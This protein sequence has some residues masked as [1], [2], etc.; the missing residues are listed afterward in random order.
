M[1]YTAVV[2]GQTIE[3]EFERHGDSEIHA[4]IGDRTYTVNAHSVEPGVYWLNLNNRSIEVAVTPAVEGYSASVNGHRIALEILDARAALRKAAHH[5]HD[6]VVEVRAPMPGKIVKI[7][8]AE[9][10]EVK[11]NQGL[12]VME[13]MKMQN[14]IKSPKAGKVTK[15]A[16]AEATT[17][18]AGE[19]LVEVE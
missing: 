5:G 3:I 9:G 1:K 15:L 8:V 17:V 19:L 4:R 12:V 14:E 10:A 7:L 16:V 13:A 6:G 11:A 2:D 18:N